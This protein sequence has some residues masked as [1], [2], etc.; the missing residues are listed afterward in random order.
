[1][2]YHLDT[3]DVDPPSAGW[4]EP[5]LE[6]A[7]TLAGVAAG[8]IELTLVDDDT[9]AQLHGEHCGDPSTTDVLTFDLGDGGPG[10]DAATPV[11]GDILI[12]RDEA[13]RQAAAR[14]HDAR[15]ELLLYAVHGLL[16]LLGEDDRDPAAFTQ[17]HRRE[18]Q[19]LTELGVGP[20]F[21]SPATAGEAAP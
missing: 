13:R 14:G 16:H 2:S 8:R 20:R 7:M 19:L 12:C 18:D 10:R 1:V 17:M 6:R 15:E 5:I 11:E 3:P 9:M 21:H 4:L